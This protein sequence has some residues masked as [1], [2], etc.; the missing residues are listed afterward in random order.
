MGSMHEFDQKHSTVLFFF[1]RY[2]KMILWLVFSVCVPYGF[3]LIYL[4]NS[5]VKHY[6]RHEWGVSKWDWRSP[7][8]PPFPIPAYVQMSGK[9]LLLTS[10]Q[11]FQFTAQVLHFHRLDDMVCDL[12][13]EEEG[14]DELQMHLFVMLWYPEAW[15]HA[16]LHFISHFLGHSIRQ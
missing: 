15:H 7:L 9:C 1:I 8:W 4:Q 11:S 16:K 13:K 10:M 6:Q 3:L 5:R 12:W 2:L 14:W